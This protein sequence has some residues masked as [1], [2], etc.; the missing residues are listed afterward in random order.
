MASFWRHSTRTP[1]MMATAPATKTGRVSRSMRHTQNIAESFAGQE[2][3]G[4]QCAPPTR[5]RPTM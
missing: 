5:G 2:Q 1:K 4:R 3:V